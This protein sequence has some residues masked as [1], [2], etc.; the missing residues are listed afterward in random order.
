[1]ILLQGISSTAGDKIPKVVY[2]FLK[3]VYWKMEGTKM[4]G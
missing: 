3:T 2:F 1:M 4:R